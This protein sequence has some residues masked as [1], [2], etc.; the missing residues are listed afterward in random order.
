MSTLV[1]TQA[2]V[3]HT[4]PYAEHSVVARIFTRQLGAQSCMVSGVRG[5]KGR[6]RQNQLQPLSH[7]EV[8][9]YRNPRSE[10]HRLKELS[11][12]HP[13]GAP[14]DMALAAVRMF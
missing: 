7:I 3:L 8:T 13:A 11:L 10:M 6:T 5:G 12:V 1:T 14:S 2:I 9:L 4:T